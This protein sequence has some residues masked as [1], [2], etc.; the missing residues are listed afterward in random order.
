[1]DHLDFLYKEDV[2]FVGDFNI[3]RFVAIYNFSN[4]FLTKAGK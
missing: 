3:P 1:M 4:L 2:I